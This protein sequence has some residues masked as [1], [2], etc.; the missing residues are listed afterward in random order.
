M[1]YGIHER[2][3]KMI[4]LRSM[5][6]CRRVTRTRSAYA[7]RRTNSSCSLSIRWGCNFTQLVLGGGFHPSCSLTVRHSSRKRPL[8]RADREFFGPQHAWHCFRITQSAFCHF[9]LC[10]GETFVVELFMRDLFN[11]TVFCRPPSLDNTK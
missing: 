2:K 4:G 10:N 9:P 7:I 11:V 3:E 1:G 5:R 8:G 6:K